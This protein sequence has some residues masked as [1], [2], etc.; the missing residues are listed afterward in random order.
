MLLIIMLVPL[1]CCQGVHHALILLW[2]NV[3][4]SL[5]SVQCCINSSLLCNKN[6]ISVLIKCYSKVVSTLSRI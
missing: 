2:N 3:V 6:R 5:F 4:V 1:L